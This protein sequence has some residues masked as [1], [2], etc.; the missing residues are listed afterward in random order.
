MKV[1]PGRLNHS[2]SHVARGN[3]VAAGSSLTS[4]RESRRPSSLSRRRQKRAPRSAATSFG[5]LV[6]RFATTSS[7]GVFVAKSPST[8]SNVSTSVLFRFAPVPQSRKKTTARPLEPGQRV[9]DRALH[10]PRTLSSGRIRSRNPPARSLRAGRRRRARAS[11]SGSSRRCSRNVPVRRSSVSFRH[12]E[13]PRVSVSASTLRRKR[14]SE[15]RERGF[16]PGQALRLAPPNRAEASPSS[17][18][19]PG[20]RL[21]L[22]GGWRSSSAA[23]SCTARPVPEA[24]RTACGAPR[25]H[26]APVWACQ[27]GPRTSA[28]HHARARAPIAIRHVGSGNAA[29]S[30]ESSGST[31]S[32]GANS[33]SSP[34]RFRLPVGNTSSRSGLFGASRAPL[35]RR[36]LARL[37]TSR[38]AT[39]SRSRSACGH[40]DRRL[41]GQR[42]ETEPPRV[43]RATEIIAS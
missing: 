14:P 16:N 27:P 25:S 43:V 11:L 9:A 26:L 41:I 22:F 29:H 38:S 35:P 15:R 33:C 30:A 20:R 8:E 39:R 23:S 1:G 10:E 31:A 19:S 28:A 32:S 3:R 13:Q 37:V 2:D 5:I 24:I 21:R 18:A 4:A 42:V 7:A 36:I 12:V 17:R 34:D 40:E 6:S